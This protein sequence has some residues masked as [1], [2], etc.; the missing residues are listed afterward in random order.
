MILEREKATCFKNYFIL[1]AATDPKGGAKRGP[2]RKSELASLGEDWSQA[3]KRRSTRSRSSRSKR[4][5]ESIDFGKLMKQYFPQSLM[6]LNE[7]DSEDGKIVDPRKTSY[8]KNGE[9]Q[10]E[11]VTKADQL[12]P[13][14]GIEETEVEDVKLYVKSCLK[15]HG[16]LQLIHVYLVRLGERFGC[17]WYS[18]LSDIYLRLYDCLRK[19]LTIPAIWFGDDE[20]ISP[21]RLR[22]V[23]MISVC[24]SNGE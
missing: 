13:A 18:G 24:F 14:P 3:Y 20:D 1:C 19:H 21:S 9:G 23:Q 4:E 2:K 16:L 10:Q 22:S 17:R 8:D 11:K 15:G 7:E 12:P 6:V 5:V